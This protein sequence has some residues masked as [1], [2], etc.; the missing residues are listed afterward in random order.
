MNERW[1]CPWMFFGAHC[2]CGEDLSPVAID[3][4]RKLQCSRIQ[5]SAQLGYRDVASNVTYA[6]PEESMQ[7]LFCSTNN[8]LA[9]GLVSGTVIVGTRISTLLELPEYHSMLYVAADE[10]ELGFQIHGR[11]R[12]FVWVF[13]NRFSCVKQLDNCPCWAEGY[14]LK[15]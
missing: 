6:A 13:E 12:F 5:D 15:A 3:F 10:E 11:H 9:L 8:L 2:I 14:V 1:Y 4:C 7:L